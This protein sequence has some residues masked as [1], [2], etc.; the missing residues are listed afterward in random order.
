MFKRH[1][2]ALMPHQHGSHGPDHE[3][4]IRPKGGRPV[5]P[6]ATDE[7]MPENYEG[8]KEQDMELCPNDT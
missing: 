5:S 7:P 6:V 3:R 8:N 2:R 1:L 4:I